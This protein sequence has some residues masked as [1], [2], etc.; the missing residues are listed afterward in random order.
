MHRVICWR[1]TPGR[2]T[3]PIFSEHTGQSISAARDGAALAAARGAAG[4]ITAGGITLECESLE[5]EGEPVRTP[6]RCAS[7]Q[8]STKAHANSASSPTSSCTS[9]CDRAYAGSI[10]DASH[11][12]HWLARSDATATCARI[13]CAYALPAAMTARARASFLTCVMRRQCLQSSPGRSVFRTRHPVQSV[14]FRAAAARRRP[15]CS[16]VVWRRDILG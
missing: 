4:G 7:S 2:S 1:F 14:R 13:R 9:A 15:A 10:I 16:C 12:S 5:R 8:E 6:M 3:G 11:A